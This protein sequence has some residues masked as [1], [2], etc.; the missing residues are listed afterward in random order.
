MLKACGAALIACAVTGFG[1]WM[2]VREK[3]R[4]RALEAS[5]QAIALLKPAV[6]I[7]LLPLHDAIQH[8]SQQNTLLGRLNA[9][10]EDAVEENLKEYGLGKEETEILLHLLAS[11][12]RAAAG[13]TEHF[14]AATEQLSVIMDTRRKAAEQA[15]ALYPKLGLLGG[16][17]VFLMLL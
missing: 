2:T 3:K 4:V 8:L 6:C 14:D 15:A 12:P 9:L 5:L 10:K 11:I 1:I 16:A 13:S 7:Q 17:V